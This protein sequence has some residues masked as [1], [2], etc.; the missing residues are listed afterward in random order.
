MQTKR[1]K[2]YAPPK[3]KKGVAQMRENDETEVQLSQASSNMLEDEHPT[4]LVQSQD[5]NLHVILREL[6]EFRKD[7]KQK[8]GDIREDIGKIYK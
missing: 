5:A 7:N 8:L 3:K 6:R 4:D 1:A 2:D